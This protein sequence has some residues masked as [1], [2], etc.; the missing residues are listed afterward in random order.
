MHI[1]R[2]EILPLTYREAKTSV[3]TPTYE[4]GE[5]LEFAT[6]ATVCY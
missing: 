5:H 1:S 3:K 2:D 4:F 6:L